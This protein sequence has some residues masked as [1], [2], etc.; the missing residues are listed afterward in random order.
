MR[1]SS[2]DVRRSGARSLA[3]AML[4]RGVFAASTPGVRVALSRGLLAASFAGV[5][6]VLS[7]VL[8]A[9]CADAAGVPT[10]I[11]SPTISGTPQL[12]QTLTEGHGSWT[13]TPTRY[14]YH[15]QRCDALGSICVAIPG[16]TARTYTLTGS[17]VGYAI[18]VKETA[19]NA[20]GAS[21]AASSALTAVVTPAPAPPTPPPTGTATTV[22]TLVASPT[23]PVVNEAVTLVA[24]V[25]S[26]DSA[27]APAGAV[28]FR[29]GGSAIAGCANE[30]AESA[31]Q[32]VVVTCQTWFAASTAQLSAVFSPSAGSTITGSTSP[33]VSLTI[34]RDATSTFLDVSK[35]VGVRAST[36]YTATVNS[37]P[38]RLGSLQPTGTVGFF[39]E[40]QAIGSCADQ[41]LTNGGATCTVTYKAP[42]SHSITAEYAGD[43]N[44]GGSSAPAQ[45]VSVIEPPRQ[46]L[47]LI[48]STMQWTF[49]STSAYTTVL[50]LVV[51]GASGATLTTSCQ[52]R[53]CPFK[54][55][56]TVVT[57]TKRCGQKVART[58]TAQGTM[59]LAPRFRNRRLSVGVQ[60]TIAITRT[61]WIGKYYRFTVRA[62]QAPHVQI[63]CLA[64][65]ATRPGSGC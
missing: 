3:R 4:G 29:N 33:T 14:T 63:A 46:V 20:A 21:K 2:L 56:R 38:G 41:P 52:G 10:I 50:R 35:T 39:D 57:K 53:G 36:T 48:S 11:S 44:F 31:G 28:T 7:W 42:G 19:H 13:N 24:V 61:G 18:S 59:D 47:G 34:G 51:N 27:A 8:L 49:Y 26:S 54:R 40:G 17:D 60:I 58:C 9:V 43:A 16:A 62:R 22:T 65:G 5:L 15:W 32:S 30:P 45:P 12:G 6:T 1:R 37:T 64:P 23:A 25:T 55:S